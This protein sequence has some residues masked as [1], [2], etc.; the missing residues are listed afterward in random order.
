MSKFFGWWR[1]PPP[2]RKNLWQGGVEGGVPTLEEIMASLVAPTTFL[3][4]L[5]ACLNFTL[6][7]EDLFCWSKQKKWT[8]AAAQ[9]AENHGDEWGLTWYLRWG[10]YIHQF[11]PEPTH[12]IKN[13]S[14]WVDR[15]N[16]TCVRLNR[17]KNSG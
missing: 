15:E 4:R 1:S 3:Q 16:F 2:N 14:R 12:P 10:G 9:I 8:M 7:S 13:I 5:L 11:Q 17:I 6:N